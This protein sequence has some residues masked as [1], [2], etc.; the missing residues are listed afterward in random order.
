MNSFND[1]SFEPFQCQSTL[2]SCVKLNAMIR[3]WFTRSRSFKRSLIRQWSSQTIII[4]IHTSQYTGTSKSV[5]N[6]YACFTRARRPTQT[7][8]SGTTHITMRRYI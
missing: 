6:H 5:I 4:C 3:G 7:H 8:T 2:S 1:N